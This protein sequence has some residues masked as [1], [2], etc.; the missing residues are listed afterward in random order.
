[1]FHG[2]G[3]FYSNKLMK[4]LL[5]RKESRLVGVCICLYFFDQ[6]KSEATIELTLEGSSVIAFARG[7][8]EFPLSDR[9]MASV[10]RA[11]GKAEGLESLNPPLCTCLICL[12]VTDKE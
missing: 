9:T 5:A 2:L 10:G 7:K 8:I 1:M 4:P 12:Q 3:G 6:M 11:Y